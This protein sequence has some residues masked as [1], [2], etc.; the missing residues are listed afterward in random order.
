MTRNLPTG[1]LTL[2]QKSELCHTHD[3]D[4]LRDFTRHDVPV[5]QLPDAERVRVE[6]WAGK[7]GGPLP[8]TATV[9]RVRQS[10]LDAQA[11]PTLFRVV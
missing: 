3:L 11:A 6:R 4:E 5:D 2:A 7:R 1:Y 8:R 9:F 10:L